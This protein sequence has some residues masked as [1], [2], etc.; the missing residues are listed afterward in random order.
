VHRS[1]SARPIIAGTG[2]RGARDKQ[3]MRIM[4]DLNVAGDRWICVGLSV[5]A[6]ADAAAAA[7]ATAAAT[8][9]TVD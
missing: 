9:F 4:K 3:T 6:A 2:V 7:A 5:S 8:Y 1:R